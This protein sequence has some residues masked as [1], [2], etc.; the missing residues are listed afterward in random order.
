[1][2]SRIISCRI[3]VDEIARNCYEFDSHDLQINQKD[4]KPEY[5]VAYKK[6]ES[7]GIPYRCL[8]PKGLKNVLVAGKLMM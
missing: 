5:E 4:G 6:G 1:M 2:T 8:T 7:H 3:F